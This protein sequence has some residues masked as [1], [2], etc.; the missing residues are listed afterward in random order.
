MVPDTEHVLNH[1]QLFLSPQLRGKSQ[2]WF[3]PPLKPA[4][5]P[6]LCTVLLT[7]KPTF[8]WIRLK[9][10]GGDHHSLKLLPP[11]LDQPSSLVSAPPALTCWWSSGLCLTW[12][13]LPTSSVSRNTDLYSRA[14]SRHVLLS[15]A[16]CKYA[17]WKS[18]FSLQI[19]FVR[20]SLPGK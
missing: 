10:W 15:Q 5:H 4:F 13:S 14:P 19:N 11:S 1:C 16:K 3:L 7:Q 6:H 18:A 2:H 20:C 17:K 8:C 9:H 12:L